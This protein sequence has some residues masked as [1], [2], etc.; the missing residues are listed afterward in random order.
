MDVTNIYPGLRIGSLFSRLY[1]LSQFSPLASP[2]PYS[3]VTSAK[4]TPVLSATD[5][6][7]LAN[8][9]SIGYAEKLKEDIKDLREA[10]EELLG[11]LDDLVVGFELPLDCQLDPKT[12][13]DRSAELRV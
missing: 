6:M 9:T 4:K 3:H 12:V 8:L 5:T 7:I 11:L 2:P 13:K 10:Y 1:Q